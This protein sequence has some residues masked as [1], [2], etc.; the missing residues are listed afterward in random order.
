MVNNRCFFLHVEHFARR[1]TG[2]YCEHLWS[3][4]SVG[5]LIII[6]TLAKLHIN[7]VWSWSLKWNWVSQ[8]CW[9]LFI[10]LLHSKNDKTNWL[11]TTLPCVSWKLFILLLHSKTTSTKQ[12]DWRQP[13]LAFP[14]L[15]NPTRRKQS[16]KIHRASLKRPREN[17]GKQIQNVTFQ[18]EMKLLNVRFNFVYYVRWAQLPHHACQF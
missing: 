17:F 11:K 7:K 3:A 4:R 1:K 6:P 9:K 12:T 5:W 8:E 2:E 15:R 13:Y 16:I 10:L 14:G 18:R